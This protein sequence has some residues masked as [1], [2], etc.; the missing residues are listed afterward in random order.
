[1]NITNAIGLLDSNGQLR[2]TL[3]VDSTTYQLQFK[4]SQVSPN[5]IW[6][7]S[8]SPTPGVSAAYG[9]AIVEAAPTNKGIVPLVVN[10]V[11][12]G[13]VGTSETLIIR[14]TATFND[15][16]TV[17]VTHSF[18]TTGSYFFTPF[19]MSEIQS[20]A[21]TGNGK[22]I[23][24]IAIDSQTSLTATSATTNTNLSGISV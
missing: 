8:P 19:E 7:V 13:T 21:S 2:E 9:T 12:S 23:T 18:T 17:Q 3:Q 1:M 6:A 22:Y 20:Q 10:F 24:Q 16:T 14:A 15:G 5:I 4:N 11:V